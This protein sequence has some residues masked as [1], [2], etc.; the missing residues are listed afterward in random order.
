MIS[1]GTKVRTKI[2][3]SPKWANLEGVVSVIHRISDRGLVGLTFSED[4]MKK[5]SY[6][7]NKSFR[8]YTDE[9]DIIID[10]DVI[11]PDGYN[12]CI[13]GTITSNKMWCCECVKK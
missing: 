10:D 7:E 2:G 3:L 1:I 4:V 13:C 11:L 8:F 5:L 6:P 12:R 9:F